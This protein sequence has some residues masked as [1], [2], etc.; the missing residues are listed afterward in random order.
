MKMP[1]LPVILS[2][3]VFQYKPQSD[4]E[5]KAPKGAK[6]ALIGDT[7]ATEIRF[8]QEDV[9]AGFAP[10]VGESV[11][12]VTEPFPWKMDNGAA[13]VSFLYRAHVTG[14]HINQL[15]AAAGLSTK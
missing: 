9:E 5:S 13:G 1:E 2:G 7:G 14:E 8:S 15:A 4:F 10:S 3:T 11:C 6:V 12:L